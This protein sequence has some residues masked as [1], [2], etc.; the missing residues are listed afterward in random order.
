[1][2]TFKR[3]T[4]SN[5]SW[6]LVN[7]AIKQAINF[8]II[9]CLARVLDP[10]DFGLVAM[11]AIFTG[12]MSI[13]VEQGF[14]SAIIQKQDITRLHLDSIFWINLVFGLLCAMIMAALASPIASFFRTPEIKILTMAVAVNFI[15]NSIKIVPNAILVKDMRFRSIAVIDT[16]SML[17]AGIISV[18]MALK[19]F[20]AWSLVFQT[21]IMNAVNAAATYASVSW[22]PRARFNISTLK[23]VSGYSC[24][25]LGFNFINYWARN[26]DNLIVGRFIGDVALGIYS[27]AYQVMLLPLNQIS[28]VV[29]RVMF[30]ALSEI[31]HDT[32]RVKRIYLRSIQSI[33]LVTFPLM[34][35]LFAVSRNFVLAVFGQKWIGVVPILNIFCWIGLEHSVSTTVGWIYNSQ[36]RTDLQFRWGLVSC[37]IIITSFLIGLKWGMIGIAAAYAI[38]GYGITMYWDWTIPGRLIDLRFTEV[39]R[40]LS[41]SLYCSL[42][43]GATVW[44]V[45]KLLPDGM[46]SWACLAVQVPCGVAVYFALIHKFSLPAYNE[47]K[48]IALGDKD[49]YGRPSD[50]ILNDTFK[51]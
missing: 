43:M 8:I 7:N 1:M 14:S 9:V 4:V 28:W 15:I 29:S 42:A 5:I 11:V 2:S 20:G 31:Q 39:V 16:V 47:F 50:A 13:F 41:G 38:A 51:I 34:V 27:R 21:I 19:G 33:S 32:G 6:S 49:V 36:G 26:F 12:F 25:L 44:A 10:K 3:K 46:G 40:A 37:I 18:L 48:K 24:N 45:G 35:G 17:C 30:P 22:R 23:E